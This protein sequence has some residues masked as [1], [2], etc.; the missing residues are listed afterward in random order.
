MNII[1]V[2]DYAH[3]EGGASSV[4]I[5]SAIAFAKSGHNVVFFSSVSPIDA[6]LRINGIEVICIESSEL[7]T[8]RLKSILTGIWN[9]RSRNLLSN[10][11]EK[12]NKT[13]TKIFI[14]SWTKSLSASIFSAVI[15]AK[16]ES[17]LILHDYF[18][19]CPNGAFYN[20]KQQK[21]CDFKP[22]G[23]SCIASNC[24]SRSYSIKIWRL[25]RQF[26]LRNVLS[27]YLKHGGKLIFVS[28]FSETKMQKYLPDNYLSKVLVTPIFGIKHCPK[29]D[30]SSNNMIGFIGRLVDEKGVKFLA[31]SLLPYADRVVFIGSGPLEDY[32]RKKSNKYTITGWLQ[33]DQLDDVYRTLRFNIFSSEIFETDGLVIKEIGKLGIPSIVS[34]LT[35]GSSYINN[36]DNGI[37]Y[38]PND[39]SNLIDKIDILKNDK[40]LDKISDNTHKYFNQEI[41]SEK[42]YINNLLS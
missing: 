13:E 36:G 37:I 33:H 28:E 26:I 25:V 35:A 2:S 20:F 5:N 10:L 29:I 12:Y 14:H 18:S 30:V 31:D 32:I 15:K 11:L 16:F 4:A 3:I 42:K 17:S 6:N 39:S 7:T 19:V 22:L 1:I 9:I 34:S 24:D 40:T 41:S 38:K 8:N 21:I 27:K 23:F